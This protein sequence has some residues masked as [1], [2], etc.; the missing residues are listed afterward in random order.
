MTIITRV[1]TRK[2]TRDN[3]HLVSKLK[4]GASDKDTQEVFKLYYEFSMP[5]SKVANHQI[6]AINRGENEGVLSGSIE[7]SMLP[8]KTPSFSPRLM[9]KIWWFATLL[10]GILNS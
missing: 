5:I 3:G 10:I 8:D 6:L 4:R 1:L 7:A 9:A 2:Y